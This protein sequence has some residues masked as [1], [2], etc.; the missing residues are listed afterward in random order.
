MKKVTLYETPEIE[1]TRFEI[2]GRMMAGDDGNETLVPGDGS[3]SP[4]DIEIGT[5]DEEWEWD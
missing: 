1:V 4:P 5:G 2:T 3:V